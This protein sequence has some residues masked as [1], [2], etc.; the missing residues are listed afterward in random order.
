LTL[1]KRRAAAGFSLLITC[2][3]ALALAACGGG[4]SSQTSASAQATFDPQAVPTGQVGEMVRYGH[5]LI[6]HTRAHLKP[7]VTA[8]MDCAACHVNA[9]TK[10]RGGTFV[11][12]AAQFPQWN[13]RAKRV[14]SLQ[15]RLAECFLYS[16]NGHPP[17][18]NSREM[19]AMVA[20][21]TYLSRGTKI[22]A[23]PDPGA[24]LAHFDPPS[25]P[26]PKRGAQLYTQK[27]SA[28]HGADGSGSE[29]FP[30]L[31]GAKSFN[32]GAGMHRLWTMAGFVRYNMP[33]N[34]PGTLSDQEAYD[35]S[36]YVL[37]HSRPKFNKRKIV[38]F[39]EQD[40]GYF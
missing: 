39:P 23:K 40:A 20:Y 13:S 8:N 2:A 33:Q 26:D 38:A 22:G 31:W 36:A 19:E 28:C 1:R 18:Y 30:P 29:Q 35:V 21:I 32:A 37:S 10:P 14:I 15:D 5:E 25:A 11:G 3:A 7:F 12:I 16:M 34:A 27:C 17:A 24:R 4:G 6:V 9:G